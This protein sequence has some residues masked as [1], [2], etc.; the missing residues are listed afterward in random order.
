MPPRHLAR[1][2][3]A[4]VLDH[5]L[6]L[7]LVTALFL[8]FAGSGLR[9]PQPIAHL[10]TVSCADLDTPPDWLVADLTDPRFGVLRLC[11]NNLWGRPNGQEIIAAYSEI[12][13]DGTRITSVTREAVDAALNPTGLPDLSAATVLTLM[14]LIA[15]LT[16]VRGWPSPGK[17]LVRLRVTSPHPWRREILRLGPLVLLTGL[18]AL[19]PFEPQL[20][21][22]GAILGGSALMALGLTW[23]YLWPFAHWSG[24]SRHDRLSGG[25]VTGARSA[26]VPPPT[27]R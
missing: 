21:P 9:L 3:L 17:A 12:R 16:T 19:I 5:T 11:Q 25:Q 15:A 26:P 7:L 14:A 22:F 8:P 1:R 27:A 2:A 24:Q 6:A 10:R 20:W 18:P 23:Y 13:P 4:F